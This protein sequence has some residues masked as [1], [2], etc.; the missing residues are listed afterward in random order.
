MKS[1]NDQLIIKLEE[2]GVKSEEIEFI[3]DK[4]N[5]HRDSREYSDGKILDMTI[6]QQIMEE[7]DWRKRA[8]LAALIISS[9]IDA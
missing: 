8:S 9:N 2:A 5:K 7:K 1:N 3:T 4:L 6:K